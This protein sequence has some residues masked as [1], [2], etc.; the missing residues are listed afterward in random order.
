MV[1][2]Q[3]RRVKGIFMAM[4]L[5]SQVAMSKILELQGSEWKS[6]LQIAS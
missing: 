2:Q 1:K 4:L 6:W 3:N 5:I